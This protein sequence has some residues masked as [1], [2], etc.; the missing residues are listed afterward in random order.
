MRGGH[1]KKR[2]RE[3]GKKR[4][5][6]SPFSPLYE[7]YWREGTGKRL[8]GFCEESCLGF[9]EVLHKKKKKPKARYTSEHRIC[10]RLSLKSYF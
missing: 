6:D 4:R 5:C 1:N 10:K 2:W 7:S 9:V 8:R 3:G